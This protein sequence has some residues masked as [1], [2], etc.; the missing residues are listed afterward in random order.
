MVLATDRVAYWAHWI[1][2]EERPIRYDTRFFVAAAWPDQVAEPD[3]LEMVARAMD[4][5]RR[6]RW[7]GTGLASWSCRYRPRGSSR[8]SSDH[9]G[10]RR[11][12]GGGSRA[13]GPAR[14]PAH[15]PGRQRRRAHPASSGSRLVL[16]LAR[17]VASGRI[18]RMAI[19][20]RLTF[21]LALAAVIL[22]TAGG[23]LVR[24]ADRS[25]RR[26]RHRDARRR[27]GHPRPL[28]RTG[29]RR[30]GASPCRRAIRRRAARSSRSSS[31]T[32]ATRCAASGS[33]PRTI[34]GG[35]ARSFR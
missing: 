26:L 31:A 23:D 15:R 12:P 1:T 21:T 10:R 35:R 30:A 34:P 27:P 13:R 28:T 7:R 25:D 29:R 8:P 11:P 18:E 32:A 22:G 3:G 19:G 6:T 14:P 33:R 4:R 2:P 5:A 20:R 16:R 9:R 17:G 24:R